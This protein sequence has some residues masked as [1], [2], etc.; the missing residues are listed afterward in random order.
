[1]R[2][3]ELQHFSIKKNYV[4]VINIEDDFVT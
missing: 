3:V 2:E 1:M 4:E